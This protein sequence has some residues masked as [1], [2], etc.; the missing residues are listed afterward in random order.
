MTPP[1]AAA[2]AF[3]RHR[4]RIEAVAA[5][6]LG[7]R[8]EARD[9]ASETYLA[10]LE[11][12]PTGSGSAGTRTD[13]EL[14]DPAGDTPAAA[15]YADLTQ[16]WY[17]SMRDASGAPTGFRVHFAT[18][19]VPGPDDEVNL[20]AAWNLDAGQNAWC[21]AS[22]S[23]IRAH[24]QNTAAPLPENAELSYSCGDDPGVVTAGPLGIHTDVASIVPLEFAF[25]GT[26]TIV[27]VPFSA[28]TFGPS[29]SRYRA[30][31]SLIG[32]TAGSSIL[33]WP[34]VVVPADMTLCPIAPGTGDPSAC[35]PRPFVLG[36]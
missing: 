15:A 3:E 8:D 32:T 7:D 30:G 11:R 25:D 9:V 19:A 35:N 1:E 13:P 5:R 6:I 21:S 17:T 33:K 29:A 26:G 34:A 24:P 23:V 20:F 14:S 10:L 31:A 16:V 28:F 27:E 4:A 2:G 36:S 18:V 12:G 22:V